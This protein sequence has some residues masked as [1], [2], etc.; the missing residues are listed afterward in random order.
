[1]TCYTLY[2]NMP[3]MY[4]LDNIC[5][6]LDTSLENKYRLEKDLLKF[7]IEENSKTHYVLAEDIAKLFYF[8][9]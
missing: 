4:R 1:M 5:Q 2:V 3:Y 9:E 7:T 8:D 6:L